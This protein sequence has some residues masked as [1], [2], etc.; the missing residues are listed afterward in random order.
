MSTLDSLLAGIKEAMVLAG[1][2]AKLSEEVKDITKQVSAMDRRLTRVE[3]T[4]D[5]AQQGRLLPPQSR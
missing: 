2:T 4:L 5:L 3:V 1:R